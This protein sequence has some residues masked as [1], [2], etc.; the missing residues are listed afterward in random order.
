MDGEDE[1]K[2]GRNNKWKSGLMD[3]MYI[4]YSILRTNSDS[5]KACYMINP[6]FTANF[7]LLFKSEDCYFNYGVLSLI[8]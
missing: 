1:R 6:Q 7:I 5:Y 4:V 8:L 3:I 2:E